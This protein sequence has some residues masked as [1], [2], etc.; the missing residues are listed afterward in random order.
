MGEVLGTVTNSR[1]MHWGQVQSN[2]ET[3]RV[4]YTLK[5]YNL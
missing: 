5:G 1:V 2:R 3:F 4:R